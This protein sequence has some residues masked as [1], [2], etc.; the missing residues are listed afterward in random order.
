MSCRSLSVKFNE[1]T[2]SGDK[3]A[4]CKSLAELNAVFQAEKASFAKIQFINQHPEITE[5]KE[6]FILVNQNDAKG[7]EANQTRIVEYV[8]KYG[9]QL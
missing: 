4:V 2:K 5:L 7:N 8:S 3:T 9:C 1:D 6:F